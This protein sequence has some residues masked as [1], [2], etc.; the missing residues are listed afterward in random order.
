MPVKAI[1]EYD[2]VTVVALSPMPSALALLILTWTP[3]GISVAT[4]ACA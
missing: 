3:G 1:E 4:W 2:H